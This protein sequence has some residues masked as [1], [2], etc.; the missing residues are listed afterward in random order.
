MVWLSEWDAVR[1]VG[2]S[3][4]TLRDWRSRGIVQCGKRGKHWVYEKDSLRVASR[5]TRER[6]VSMLKKGEQPK[7]AW[8]HW[9]SDP[10]VDPTLF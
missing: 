10:L 5:V 8:P 2:R 9:D 4:R 7:R 1:F 6:R 3:R